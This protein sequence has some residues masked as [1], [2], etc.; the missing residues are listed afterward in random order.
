MTETWQNC[1]F[2]KDK[3]QRGR[4]IAVEGSSG[5]LKIERLETGKTRPTWW[6]E[7]LGQRIWVLGSYSCPPKPEGKDSV[8]GQAGTL[9]RSFP[10]NYHS[11]ICLGKHTINSLDAFN[12]KRNLGGRERATVLGTWI[13]DHR[14]CNTLQGERKK[15]KNAENRTEGEKKPISAKN[16]LWLR[17]SREKNA[18]NIIGK[19]KSGYS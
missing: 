12:L 3:E 1:C 13:T 2:G 9:D 18:G 19:K 6:N 16:L 7:T 4:V 17:N 8:T 11:G 15:N 14:E 5:A 10:G